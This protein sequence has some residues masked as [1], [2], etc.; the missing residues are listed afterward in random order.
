MSE[1]GCFSRA[2]QSL[3]QNPVEP[4]EPFYQLLRMTLLAKLTTP[5]ELGG[6]LKIQDYRVV[7]LSHS[8][9]TCLNLLSPKQLSYC[10]G[11]S[12][13]AGENLH[14][15]WKDFVLSEAESEKFRFGYWDEAVNVISDGALKDYLMERYVARLDSL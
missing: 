8:K 6:G 13:C 15:A 5:L 3:R 9:N 14:E 4:F 2:R 1:T 12:H 7:H 10:P 11:L